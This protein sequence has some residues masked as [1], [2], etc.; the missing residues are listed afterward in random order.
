M[1]DRAKNAGE[2]AALQ[3]QG[4]YAEK[5]TRLDAYNRYGQSEFKTFGVGLTEGEQIV[6]QQISGRERRAEL[7]YAA[8]TERPGSD[9]DERVR[10]D[11]AERI[12]IEIGMLQNKANA[13]EKINELKREEINLNKQA[14]REFERSLLVSSPSELLRKMAVAGL[15]HGRTMSGPNAIT[16]GEFFS[17]SQEARQDFMRMPGNT[18]AER[19]ARRGRSALE[20]EF[21]PNGMPSAYD[22]GQSAVAGAIASSKYA[23]LI[24]DLSPQL[25][26]HPDTVS[27]I[28]DLGSQRRGLRP[29]WIESLIGMA[30]I[31]ELSIIIIRVHT[32]RP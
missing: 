30:S 1:E 12:N 23:N 8:Q 22:Q 26:I 6:Q 17:M 31:G 13:Y 27:A 9:H 4:G 7:R 24:P 21:F 15:T 29:H 2:L 25:S 3:A 5:Q 10:A 14:T 20:H 16:G 28:M 18:E 19:L 32:R 11:N